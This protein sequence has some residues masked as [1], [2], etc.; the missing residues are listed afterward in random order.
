M[1]QNGYRIDYAGVVLLCYPPHS[2]AVLDKK[3]PT[4]NIVIFPLREIQQDSSCQPGKR[5]FFLWVHLYDLLSIA[6][7]GS[8]STSIFETGT[9]PVKGFWVHVPNWTMLISF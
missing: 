1:D 5:S 8:S 6:R 4:Q 2:P 9:P 3:S 7:G